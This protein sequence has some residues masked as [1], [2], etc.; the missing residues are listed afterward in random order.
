MEDKEMKRIHL[1]VH[2]KSPRDSAMLK[3]LTRTLGGMALWIS[4]SSSPVSL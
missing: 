3:F 2:Y 4:I 1:G